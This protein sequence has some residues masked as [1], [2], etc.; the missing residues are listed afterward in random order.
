VKG[1]RGGQRPL[2]AGQ[3]DDGIRVGRQRIVVSQQEE[4]DPDRVGRNQA[5]QADRQKPAHGG[6]SATRVGRLR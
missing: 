6:N 3:R 5:E 1:L 2:G 4:R